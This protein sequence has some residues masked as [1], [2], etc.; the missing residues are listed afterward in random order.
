MVEF[1]YAVSETRS[2]SVRQVDEVRQC[3]EPHELQVITPR[4]EV[5]PR[6]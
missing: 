1:D 4:S 6:P 3:D 2:S 5:L